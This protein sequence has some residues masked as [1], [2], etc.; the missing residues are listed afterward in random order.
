MNAFLF[1]ILSF[2][3]LIGIAALLSFVSDPSRVGEEEARRVGN[4]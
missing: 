1:A 2:I 3:A 4:L